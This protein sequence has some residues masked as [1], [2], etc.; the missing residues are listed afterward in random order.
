[1]FLSKYGGSAESALRVGND[2][3]CACCRRAVPASIMQ[4]YL[5]DGSSAA[6]PQTEQF[7]YT[8][9]AVPNFALRPQSF[10]TIVTLDYDGEGTSASPITFVTRVG[11]SILGQ[12]DVVRSS[13]S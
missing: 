6:L 12:H 7:P 3:E 11:T 5:A 10:A 8:V 9:S 1:M 2:V 13:S 4:L